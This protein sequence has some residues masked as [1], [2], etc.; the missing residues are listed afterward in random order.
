MA[1]EDMQVVGCMAPGLRQ[2]ERGVA[3]PVRMSRIRGLRRL[4]RRLR[5]M[6]LMVS[7]LFSSF[8]SFSLEGQVWRRS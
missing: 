3:L 1:A 8:L 4:D 6:N 7:P 2:K 5:G